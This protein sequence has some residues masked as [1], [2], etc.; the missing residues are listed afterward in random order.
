[1][2]ERNRRKIRQVKCKK[3]L[4][5]IVQYIVSLVLRVRIELN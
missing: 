2:C 4:R 3:E 5:I 1:M